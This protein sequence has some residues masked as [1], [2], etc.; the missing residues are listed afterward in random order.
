MQGWSD[1]GMSINVI[2]HL[3]LPAKKECC[4]IHDG[5]GPAYSGSHRGSH[6]G[7]GPHKGVNV[8]PC[9]TPTAASPCTRESLSAG[10]QPHNAPGLGVA[11]PPHAG[12]APGAE[13]SD[14]DWSLW[15]PGFW[16]AGPQT[17]FRPG[18]ERRY[19]R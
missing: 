13:S 7:M 19:P 11:P 9:V 4:S 8:C 17:A 16:W 14:S 3:S 5:R 1:I 6:R 10:A 2:D 12:P 18:A 15:L